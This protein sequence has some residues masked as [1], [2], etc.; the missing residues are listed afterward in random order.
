MR[1]VLLPRV[2][3]LMP[4]PAGASERRGA[5]AVAMHAL[6]TLDAT[7]LGLVGKLAGV[8]VAADGKP[9]VHRPLEPAD[10][11]R[12]IE[13]ALPALALPPAQDPILTDRSPIFELPVG[14]SRRKESKDQ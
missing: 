5:C 7:P 3:L 2:I 11:A 6:T 1:H 4:S 8:A 12:L 14:L 9:Y 13:V 10:T